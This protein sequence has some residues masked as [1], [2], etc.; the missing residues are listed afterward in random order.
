MQVILSLLVCNI[1]NNMSFICHAHAAVTQLAHCYCTCNT[2]LHGD[3]SVSTYGSENS[4]V[5][6]TQAAPL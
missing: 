1:T 2:Q 3:H 6:Q 4:Y 5:T